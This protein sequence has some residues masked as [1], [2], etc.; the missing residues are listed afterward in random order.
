[1]E[2]EDKNTRELKEKMQL[3][4]KDCFKSKKSFN[5]RKGAISKK[6][7]DEDYSHHKKI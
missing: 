3:L 1:M 7:F 6:K 5:C 4:L 2:N